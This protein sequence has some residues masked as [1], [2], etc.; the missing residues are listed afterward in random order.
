M[1]SRATQAVTMSS[2]TTGRASTSHPRTLNARRSRWDKTLLTLKSTCVATLRDLFVRLGHSQGIADRINTNLRASLIGCYESYWSRV[3]SE[4]RL[5]VFEVDSKSFSKYLLYLFEADR[6]V[7]STVISHWTSIASVLQHWKYDPAIES[8]IRALLHNFQLA[9]PVQRK[10]MPRWN[11]ISSCQPCYD[12][13]FPMVQSIDPVMTSLTKNGGCSTQ[14]FWDLFVKLIHSQS[15]SDRISTNLRAS[16]I[17]YYESH[18]RKFVEYCLIKC[19]NVFEVDSKS[20]R[21]CLLYLFEVDGY[22]LSTIISH[23]TSIASVLQHWKYDP[24]NYPGIRGMLYNFQLPQPVQ[25]KMMPQ[26]NLLFILSA[27]LWPPFSNG[28]VDRPS[29]D[30]IGQKWGMLRTTFLLLLATVRRSYLHALCVSTCLFTHGDVH[31]HLV[32]NLLPH[33]DF[34]VKNQMPDQARQ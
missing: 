24:A 28:A 30:V 21:K 8:C 34:L 1:D 4:K 6:Y 20:F 11:F 32:V 22:I 7:P 17:G 12:L 13:P 10:M 25:W 31:N 16:L 26:W 23:W 27:L 3:L 33:A 2:D 18:W 15:I 14:H 19:L 9:R 29:N 5:K